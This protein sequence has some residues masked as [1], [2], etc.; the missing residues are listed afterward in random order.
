MSY[1]ATAHVTCTVELISQKP[2]GNKHSHTFNFLSDTEAARSP[3]LQEVPVTLWAK[4]KSDVGLI[5]NCEPLQ[6]YTM[7]LVNNTH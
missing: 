5:K 2:N 4:H 1:V 7:G 6:N 3:A